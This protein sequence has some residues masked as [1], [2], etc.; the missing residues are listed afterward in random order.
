MKR[1]KISAMTMIPE[2]LKNSKCCLKC[3]I[4]DAEYTTEAIKNMPKIIY[5][6]KK[7]R[8]HLTVYNQITTSGTSFVYFVLIL[9]VAIHFGGALESININHLFIA[10]LVIVLLFGLVWVNNYYYKIKITKFL[11]EYVQNKA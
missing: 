5:K 9:C 3:K 10:D 8:S 1:F 11:Q 4:V 2:E 7:C 6:C